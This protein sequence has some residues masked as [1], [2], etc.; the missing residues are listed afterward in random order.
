[1]A[2]AQNTVFISF[3]SKDEK[4]A[5]EIHDFLESRGISC[6]ISSKDI[7]TGSVWAEAIMNAMRNSSIFLLVLT[8]NSNE[9]SHVFREVTNADEFK[10][11]IFAYKFGKI[12]IQDRLKY[13]LA[14]INYTE[15]GNGNNHQY[16]TKL[17]LSIRTELSKPTAE[18]PPVVEQNTASDPVSTPKNPTAHPPV[19]QGHP[20][21]EIVLQEQP[22]ARS[23]SWSTRLILLFLA[24]VGC[25]YGLTYFKEPL[26]PKLQQPVKQDVT[27]QIESTPPEARVYIDD[28]YV[29]LSPVTPTVKSGILSIR[30]E[31]EGYDPHRQTVS[32]IRSEKYS[33][34]LTARTSAMSPPGLKAPVPSSGVPSKGK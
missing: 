34:K 33:Y 32:A 19:G 12:N 4:L 30:L 31:K 17:L 15:A 10:I 21:Q 11:P 20:V 2:P 16:F 9:S 14:D 6:W 25:I 22:A 26:A 13:Y 27:I 29:G 7:P 5:T 24:L 3:S 28:R 1:M 8:E 23:R 18:K